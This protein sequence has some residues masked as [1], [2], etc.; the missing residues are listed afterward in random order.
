[1]T[2]QHKMDQMT[3]N[4][5]KKPPTRPR[6]GRRPRGT[7]TSGRSW[8]R[9]Q[10]PSAGR[11]LQILKIFFITSS[12]G[13]ALLVGLGD[14]FVQ[15]ILATSDA[16]RSTVRHHRPPSRSC[17]K[18]RLAPPSRAPANS[19]KPRA[20]ALPASRILRRTESF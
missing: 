3:K 1:M 17:P 16:L 5:L 13:P 15:K 4:L 14:V 7:P 9:G 8:P 20:R 6:L 11:Q 12:P 19:V 2:R 10:R 18:P